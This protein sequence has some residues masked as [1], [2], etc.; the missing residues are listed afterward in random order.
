MANITIAIVS[1]LPTDLTS[2]KSFQTIGMKK[3]AINSHVEPLPV[4]EGGSVMDY[5]IFPTVDR[6]GI[7]SGTVKVQGV[8]QN[9]A[10]VNLY[11]RKTGQL[12]QST[13]TDMHGAFSFSCGL[14]RNVADYYAVA[15]T[16]QP[17]NAQVFDKLTPA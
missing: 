8:L 3:E 10:T 2:A 15:I 1:D 4:W 13:F 9:K 14:N 6:S 17:F 5:R 12:I 11:F 16:E 7:I